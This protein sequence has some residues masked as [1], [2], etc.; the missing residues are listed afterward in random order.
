MLSG[1]KACDVLVT[2]LIHTGFNTCC[3]IQFFLKV[4]TR[5]RDRKGEG[6]G[7]G[8]DSFSRTLVCLRRNGEDV[9]VFKQKWCDN[10]CRHDETPTANGVDTTTSQSMLRRI[11]ITTECINTALHLSVRV[12]SFVVTWEMPCFVVLA[13]IA[14][15]VALATLFHVT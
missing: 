4:L 12:V 14:P 7:A 3:F 2:L 9:E 1:S 10:P 11:A 13:D 8:K 5:L 6:V 15:T